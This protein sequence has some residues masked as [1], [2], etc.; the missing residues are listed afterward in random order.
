MPGEA[1]VVG[2]WTGGLN[3]QSDPTAVA[4]NELVKCE[5]F[6]LDLDGSLVSRPPF[7]DITVSM[8][9]GAT[10]NIQILGYFYASGVSYLIG[11]DGLNS[12]YYFTGTSWTILTNTISATAL[13]Q[14]DNKAWLL[15][16]V[17]AGN[18]GGYWTPAGGFVADANMPRGE[19]IVAHK[20]RLWVARGRDA[21]QFGTRMYFSKVLGTT[22]FWTAAPDF[23]DVGA[24]DGQN[25]VQLL[26]SYNTILIFRTASVYGFQ[27]SSDPATGQT[28]LLIP[29]IGL[30]D[31]DALTTHESYIYFMYEDRAYEMFNNRATQLNV[32]VPFKAV[33]KIGLYKPFTVSEFGNR[34][35]FSYYDTMFVFSLNTR[36]W[37]SW[38]STVFGAIG[39]IVQLDQN[40]ATPT[41]VAH[42]SMVVP[43]GSNRW[44]KTLTITDDVLAAAEPMTCTAI[45][46][47]FNY[48]AS[49][50]YKR[51]FW[52][53]VDAT[54]RNTVLAVA[55]PIV[56]NYS[57]SWAQ[58]R[59]FTWGQVKNFTWGQPISGTLSVETV[60]NTA[61]SGSMRKFVKF[62]KS[63]RFR[64]INF[65]VS[66]STD[67]S[68]NTAPV[69]LFTIVTYV[70]PKERVSKTVT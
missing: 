52:W 18:P 22:P 68:V 40:S 19:A 31:K 60:R 34:I 63:L 65:R 25:I 56:F 61:G 15:S 7:V 70:K 66:F 23:L 30:S 33:S 1:I 5:N 3:T 4:D 42:S 69:R 2:P 26:V 48:E 21:T 11:S 47:N 14:F 44:A 38:Y 54:F 62:M 35:I 36:T 20:S 53:G 64:Q 32:K 17:S 67:G 49:S 12:T 9:L 51:L 37:T 8:P 28:S 27:F 57:V 29:G 41:A 13:V 55:T 24:G 10:G 43:S 45:T 16:A 58:L 50:V 39:R 59:A 6:E 46:K